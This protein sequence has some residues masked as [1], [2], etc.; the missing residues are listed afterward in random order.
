MV[1]DGPWVVHT[2]DA[3]GCLLNRLWG[4][5]GL[6]DVSRREPLQFGQVSP[7][8]YTPDNPS[9]HQTLL[10]RVKGILSQEEATMASGQRAGLHPYLM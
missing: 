3:L 6:I 4:I 5:P 1:D 9:E 2:D 8:T 7:E 10:Q